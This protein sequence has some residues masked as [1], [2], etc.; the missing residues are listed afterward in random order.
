[1]NKKEIKKYVLDNAISY[2]GTANIKAVAGHFIAK[3]PEVKKDMTE[4]AP[5]DLQVSNIPVEVYI[6][7]PDQFEPTDNNK[8]KITKISEGGRWKDSVLFNKYFSVDNGGCKLSFKIKKINSAN[9]IGFTSLRYNEFYPY[10]NTALNQ[11]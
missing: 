2:N 4:T 9:E 10:K 3:Y 8:Y 11:S 6:A 1:M 5:P 7:K